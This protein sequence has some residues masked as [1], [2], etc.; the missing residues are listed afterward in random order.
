[1]AKPAA[2]N[3]RPRV[4]N[5]RTN[6][7]ELQTLSATVPFD[8]LALAT[9]VASTRRGSSQ[10]TAMALPSP[11]DRIGMSQRNPRN[12]AA[13]TRNAKDKN[14]PV[15]A[16]S[17]RALTPMSDNELLLDTEIF[18]DYGHIELSNRYERD[19]PEG[20]SADGPVAFTAHTVDVYTMSVDQAVHDDQD[21]RV[22][23]YRGTD[24]SG[25]GTMV[26]DDNV[27]F[28]GEPRL[29]VYQPL[30][31]ADEG[32]EIPIE[33]TGPVRIQIFVNPPRDAEEV[34][35]LIRYDL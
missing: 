27:I 3:A 10:A 8:P 5:N 29:A 6:N 35:V 20:T 24:S 22:R 18:P 30:A 28:T 16:T 21:V 17:F 25:L 2:S 4:N 33:R 1:M 11:T 12:R 23:I 9:R 13:A 19:I 14:D 34:N 15:Q 32:E 31:D 7:R 26:F